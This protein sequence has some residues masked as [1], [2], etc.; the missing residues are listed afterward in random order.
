MHCVL[1]LIVPLKGWIIA[2]SL[3]YIS[4]VSQTNHAFA[5]K[6]STTSGG[7]G[8]RTSR[9]SLHDITDTIGFICGRFI[10]YFRALNMW[11][12]AVFLLFFA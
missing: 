9:R 8:L 1:P 5:R 4:C 10:L 11:S 12:A 7:G 6:L 2:Y 3:T